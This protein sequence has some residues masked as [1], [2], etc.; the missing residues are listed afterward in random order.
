M[1]R[2]CHFGLSRTTI[3]ATSAHA[4]SSAIDWTSGEH[5]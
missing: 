3:T 1:S 5:A 4:G 2:T